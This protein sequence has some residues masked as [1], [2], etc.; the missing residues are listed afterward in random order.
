MGEKGVS[1]I[2]IYDSFSS[3]TQEWLEES[4]SE[5]DDEEEEAKGAEGEEEEDE[6]EEESEDEEGKRWFCLFTVSHLCLFHSH[7]TFSCDCDQKQA[8]HLDPDVLDFKTVTQTFQT[9]VKTLQN[10]I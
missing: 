7:F 9:H 1:F 8:Q 4:E 6:S 2:W 10:K 5:E 3:E